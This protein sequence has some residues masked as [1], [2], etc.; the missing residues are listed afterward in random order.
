MSPVNIQKMAASFGLLSF[1]ILS[2][3]SVLMGATAF[4]GVS[5]GIGGAILFGLLAWGGGSMLMKED[6]EDMVDGEDQEEDKGTQL[7]QTA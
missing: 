4:T 2:I 6:E 3:G 1:G 5:R 7:D